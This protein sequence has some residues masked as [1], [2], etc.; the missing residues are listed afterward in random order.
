MAVAGPTGREPALQRSTHS[1]RR[2]RGLADC[3]KDGMS[4][5]RYARTDKRTGTWVL[6]GEVTCDWPL[7]EIRRTKPGAPLPSMRHKLPRRMVHRVNTELQCPLCGRWSRWDVDRLVATA[8]PQNDRAEFEYIAA[9]RDF[10]NR[11]P[12][13]GK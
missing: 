13:W 7:G 1:G 4:D 10:G 12:R 8:G 6:C 9:S 5:V 11:G 3:E 2:K